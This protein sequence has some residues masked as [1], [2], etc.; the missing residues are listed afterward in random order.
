MSLITNIDKLGKGTSHRISCW[1]RTGANNDRTHTPPGKSLLMADIKG[2]GRITHIWM[3]QIAQYRDCLIKITWDNAPEPSVL[4]PLGDFFCLGH[5]MVNSFESAL[6]TAS[7]RFPHHFDVGCALNCYVPMCFKERAVIEL[8]NESDEEH[9]QYFYVDYETLPGSEVEG[10]GY[11]HAEFRRNNPFG[12]FGHALT[13]GDVRWFGNKERCAWENNYVILETKGKGHYIGCNLSIT[14]F[15]GTWWGEGDDMIWIDGYK[16]PPDLHGTGGEDYLCQACGMDNVTFL[17]SGSSLHELD[18]SPDSQY[19]EGRYGYAPDIIGGYQTAYVFH[20]ENAIRFHKEIKVTIEC[21][22]ANNLAN[23]ISSVAYWYAEAPCA[24]IQ[25][26]P[27][28]KRRPVLRDNKGN[29]IK[30]PEGECP[31]PKVAD[32]AEFQKALDVYSNQINAEN[33]WPNI[34][35]KLA[36]IQEKAKKD[37]L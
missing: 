29:W 34:K 31:G 37:V 5:G 27:A 9:L 15:K 32:N 17:R 22:H 24:A 36:A 2:P 11:F 18:T 33:K 1:D 20:L 25:P 23:E 26:P 35:E 21:G 4:C 3:T 7:T 6:F 28:R 8:V 16:W 19:A 13:N 12:G 14:N 30:D 10:R